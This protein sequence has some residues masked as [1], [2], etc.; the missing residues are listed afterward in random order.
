MILVRF[1]DSFCSSGQG[2]KDFKPV[3]SLSNERAP[4][5]NQFFFPIVAEFA[6]DSGGA[7]S[8]SSFA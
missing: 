6:I 4:L 7:S 5:Y 8:L 2:G 1:E 3:F